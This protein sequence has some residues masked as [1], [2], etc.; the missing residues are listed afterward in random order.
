[1]EL[2]EGGSDLEYSRGSMPTLTV[3]LYITAGTL[4]LSPVCLYPLRQAKA[5]RNQLLSSRITRRI[6]FQ[7]IRAKIPT[8]IYFCILFRD[9]TLTAA[10]RDL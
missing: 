1:M 6:I 8:I 10:K 5:L 7:A 9:L 3:M 4:F 2:R